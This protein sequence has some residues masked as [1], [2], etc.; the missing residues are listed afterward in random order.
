M[1][2]RLFWAALWVIGIPLPIVAILY[3][4]FGR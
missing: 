4:L 1:G 2:N 3:F